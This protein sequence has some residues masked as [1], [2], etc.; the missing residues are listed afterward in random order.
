MV[1]RKI[2]AQDDEVKD[3][4]IGLNSGSSNTKF[5]DNPEKVE[6]MMEDESMDIVE[7]SHGVD[8]VSRSLP[9]PSVA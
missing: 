4:N 9:P 7:G 3:E 8:A 5:E 2:E 6:V 1:V